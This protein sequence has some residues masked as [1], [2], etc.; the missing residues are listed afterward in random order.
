MYDTQE[1]GDVTQDSIRVAQ[2]LGLFTFRRSSIDDAF[3]LEVEPSASWLGL[4]GP[5]AHALQHL[6]K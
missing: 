4:L 5:V 3:W 1:L 6:E 2:T